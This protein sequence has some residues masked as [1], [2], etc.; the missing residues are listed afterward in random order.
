VT[1]RALLEELAPDRFVQYQIV[2]LN[3][4]LQNGWRCLRIEFKAVWT[5]SVE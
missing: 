3:A 5:E 2:V 4:G 1:R